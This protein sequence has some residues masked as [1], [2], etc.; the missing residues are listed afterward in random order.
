MRHLTL[1]CLLAVAPLVE[2]S[3]QNKIG[4]GAV[5][6]LYKSLCASCH[7]ED[8][9]G[10]LGNSL[11]DHNNWKVVGKSTTF[12]E[13]VKTGN[14]EMGMPPF[15]EAL[16]DPQIR[17]LE[18]YIDEMR[19]KSDREDVSL[20]EV[21]DG[22]Y[23]AGGY[24]F[25]VET[26]VEGLSKPWSVAFHPSGGALITERDGAVRVFK[27]GTLFDPVEGL[28]DVWAHGQ[29]GMLEVAVHPDYEK[30][31]WIYLAFSASGGT[32]TEKGKEKAIGMTKV[33]RGRVI[34]N[35]WVDE[36]V[37]FEAPAK[38]HRSAGAHYGTRLVFKDGYLFFSIGDRGAMDMAQDLSKPNGKIH[39]VHDDGRIPKDNPFVNTPD[40]YPTIWTYGNRNPQ[41]LDLHPLTGDIWE[42]EHGP[43]GGDEINRLESGKN[44]G[45]PVIT[46]G[47]NYNGKPLTALTAKDGMEQP[48]HYWT[49]SIAVCG[50]D[51]YEGDAF[52]DWKYDLLVGG[53][54]SK[55]LHRL[56]IEN[57]KVVSDEIILHG[58]GR[59]RDVASGPDGYI[60]VVLNGPDEV[61]RLVPVEK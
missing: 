44:Y 39:R 3:A 2:L 9:N 20:V 51:F 7:G 12:L 6:K 50:I 34:D 46:Y 4:T 8:L 16:T 11:L 58:L 15:G 54:A 21:S 19:Q 31:G 25:K 48:Q 24:Q 40:A 5:D 38:F 22:V 30:N 18:I 42:S 14:L 35:Q 26:M 47:M 55:E 33:A 32:V 29:G 13:Y 49:P 60:Y 28:P 17:S 10:G 53:L 27:D 45:W 56:E 36:E 59:V 41:G 1:S 52:P 43:R 23:S 57:G 37:I 61:V